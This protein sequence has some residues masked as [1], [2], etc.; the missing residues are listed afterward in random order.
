MSVKPL[1]FLLLRNKKPNGFTLIELL[2]VLAILG[3]LAGLVA[4]QVVRYL[5]TAKTETAKLQIQMIVSALE[6]YRLDNGRYPNQ[7]EGLRALSEKPANAVR[8]NGPYLRGALPNDPWD[9]AYLYRQPGR[10][11]AEFEVY[12]LGADGQPGGT[13]EAADVFSGQK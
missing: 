9:R 4:P 1:G 2:V 12:T 13:G 3:L 10:Q 5:G 6:M 8:W 7:A 11:G